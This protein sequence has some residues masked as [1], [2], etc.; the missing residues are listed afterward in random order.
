MVEGWFRVSEPEADTFVVEEPLHRERVASFLLVGRERALLIDA[1]MGVVP[2]RPVVASLTD[3]PVTLLL[4]HAHFDHVGSAH[5]FVGSSPIVI[6]GLEAARLEA[7]WEPEHLRTYYRPDQ[8]TGPLPPGFDPAAATIPGVTPTDRLRG[9]ES[10]DLGDRSVEVLWCPGHAPGLL[11]LL[12]RQ[13]RL[14]FST[15]VAYAGELYAHFG[16]ADVT[17]YRQ[18][19]RR[20]A[21]LM[22]AYDRVYASHNERPIE[23]AI[24]GRMADAFDALA[25]GQAADEHRADASVYRY[26]GFSILV[27]P[28]RDAGRA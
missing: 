4:S 16:G 9:G 24:V 21:D 14:L 2:L 27:P 22:P 17:A 18:T 19:M 23:P 13:R 3:K 15:D 7:G 28:R 10:I 26:E 12:D 25:G 1:G 20:L 8:L 5:E 6:H 11:A